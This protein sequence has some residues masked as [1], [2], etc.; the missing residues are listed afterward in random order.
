MKAPRISL[1][2]KFQIKKKK[3]NLTMEIQDLLEMKS[4]WEGLSP[5]N[6]NALSVPSS[7]NNNQE[8]KSAPVAPITRDTVSLEDI[9]R[10]KSSPPPPPPRRR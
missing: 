5:N 1:D 10:R 9:Q 2:K 7:V 4:N 6:S 8:R 3:E